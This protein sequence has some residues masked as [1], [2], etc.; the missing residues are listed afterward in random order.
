[1]LLEY[2]ENMAKNKYNAQQVEEKIRNFWK[3]DKI[4]KFDLKR[5][6]EIFSVDTPPPYI[7]G[8]MHIGHAFSY[9]QQDFIVRFRRMFQN[10]FYPFGTDDNGLPTER[11]IERINNVKS[12]NMSRAEFISLCLNTLKKETPTCIEDFKILGISADYDIYYSTIDDHSRKISQKSF[13]DLYKN[14]LIYRTKVATPWC[15]DCQT[16]I[17]QAELE[18]K[19]EN[20]LFSI[21][22]FKVE[23]VGSDKS[24][25]HKDLLIATTRPELLGAC[26]AVFVNPKDKKYKSL[27]GKK[28]KVPLF[29][30]EVP[31]L[32]DESADIEKGTGVLMVCSYGDRFDVDAIN[33]H[34]LEPKIILGE[35]G[36][37]KHGK[38]KGLGVRE[39]RKK[40]LEDL[41][42]SKLIT[43][44]EEISHVVNVHDKCGCEIEFI[45]TEQWFIKILDKKKKLIEQG[46]KVKWYPEHMRKR[47]ENWIKGL[48]WDW[49]ISR[50]RHFG[51][52]I[53]IWYCNDCNEIILANEKELPVDPL[54]TKKKCSKCGKQAIGE[55]MVLDTWATSSLTP[56]IALGLIDNK[57]KIP[58]SLRP[59][60]HDIIRTWA[61]YTIVKSL[62]HENNIPWKD[63]MVSGYVTLG[64]K[65]MSKSKGNVINPYDIMSK[66]G[67]DALRYWAAGSKLGEDLNYQEED[68]VTGKKFITKLFNAN[69]FVFMNLK[70]FNFKKPSKLE[71]I[72]KLFLSKLNSLVKN[73]TKGFENYEYS[74]AKS[75][76]ERFFWNMFADNYLETVKKRIYQNKKGKESAQYTLYKSLLTILKL[77]SPI[78]PFITEEIYQENFKKIEKNKSIHV[79]EWPKIEK[80]SKTDELDLF[81]D[82]LVKIRQEKTNTKK[83]MN[84]ECVVFLSKAEQEKISDMI[85]DLKD[86]MNAKDIKTG[87][88]KVEFI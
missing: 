84:A 44:E 48:E 87:K 15:V 69:R 74:K 1:L 54:Q 25:N 71:K 39:A 80:E 46:K 53:P 8:R 51:V 20:S 4:Y 78:T 26:V 11:F 18:D 47:Y 36:K 88:F 85:E 73:V 16:S 10:V 6:G 37:I 17:A 5:K 77:F 61:F 52:S 68:L 56:Q 9:A 50:N 3:K 58:M 32:E 7:S 22:K 59:Q 49:S 29:N 2:Q 31:I 45:P 65:K 79:S 62:Y 34:K 14:K 60:A 67:A 64:G 63:I 35:D 12:K 66:F 72:D 76:T 42:A 82:I 86:V 43:D 70:D 83:A 24:E 33:K 40:T 55:K 75:K 19:E 13:I 28:A 81:I 21:L 23:N 57:L 27:V 41:R 30:H 38:Y